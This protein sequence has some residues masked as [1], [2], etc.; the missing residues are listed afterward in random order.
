MCV[1]EIRMKVWVWRWAWSNLKGIE[2][3]CRFE[4]MTTE[5]SSVCVI[6]SEDCFQFDLMMAKLKW[7]LAL[8]SMQNVLWFIQRETWVSVP[9]F[10]AI[11]PHDVS[12]W[13]PKVNLPDH[14][15]RLASSCGKQKHS[16]KTCWDISGRAKVKD[17]VTQSSL[18]QYR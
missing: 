7:H 6:P 13:A 8:C 4:I 18:E 12:L 11:H 3:T 9:E 17:Q 16:S 2:C 14:Q 15:S 5:L 1:V 10:M